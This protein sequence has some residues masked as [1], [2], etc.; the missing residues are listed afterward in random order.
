MKSWDP[1]TKMLGSDGCGPP[2][3]P[4]LVMLTVTSR[5]V[6]VGQTLGLHFF[7]LYL[8]GTSK[9]GNKD[10]FGKRLMGASLNHL[11]RALT[12]LKAVFCV[13]HVF[14]LSFYSGSDPVAENCRFWH[15][16]AA[17]SRSQ[18]PLITKPDRLDLELSSLTRQ[19]PLG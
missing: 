17:Q 13:E 1:I 9:L 7:K 11:V 19:S 6:K 4:V 14:G 18:Q 5:A 15:T 10:D 8:F 16:A 2:R 3:N 12:V